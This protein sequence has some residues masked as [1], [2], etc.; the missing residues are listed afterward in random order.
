[1]IREEREEA[2]LEF[3]RHSLFGTGALSCT[4]RKITLPFLSY[5][6]PNFEL[7][8]VREWNEGY[9]FCRSPFILCV[10]VFPFIFFPPS[11]P[12]LF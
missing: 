8:E 6:F 4:F 10:V 3:T 7:S 5:F 1:M 2:A 11:F 9:V 12:V